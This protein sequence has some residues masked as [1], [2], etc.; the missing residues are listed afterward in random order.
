MKS[1]LSK[2][3]IGTLCL[4]FLTVNKPVNAETYTEVYT[5][6][7]TENNTV[8]VLCDVVENYNVDDITVLVCEMPTG[9]LHEYCILDAPEGDLEIACLKT[10]NQDDYTMYEVIAVR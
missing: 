5:E 7:Y 9:E 1:I 4:A 3:L 8:Y 6:A 2:C 10:E